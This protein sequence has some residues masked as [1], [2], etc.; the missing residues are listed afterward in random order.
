M[1]TTAL[2]VGHRIHNETP[3]YTSASARDPQP[4]VEVVPNRVIEEE[5]GLAITKVESAQRPW[6][7]SA[8]RCH[9]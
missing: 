7:N 6:Q 5:E 1:V 9:C 4:R 2:L 3:S 8:L